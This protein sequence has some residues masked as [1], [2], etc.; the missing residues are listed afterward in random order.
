M[1]QLIGVLAYGVFTIVCAFIIFYAIK[2]AIGIRVSEEEERRGLD[3][4]EHGME[5]YP[6]FQATTQV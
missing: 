3:I 5:S 4:T 6:D 2:M 1:V